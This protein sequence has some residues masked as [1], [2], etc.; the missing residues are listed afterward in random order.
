MRRNGGCF[1]AMGGITLHCR[2]DLNAMRKHMSPSLA[3][4]CGKGAISHVSTL[5]WQMIQVALHLPNDLD[6]AQA[7]LNDH[8]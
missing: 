3:A 6:T 1:D 5:G 7:A 8:R 4:M 2:I